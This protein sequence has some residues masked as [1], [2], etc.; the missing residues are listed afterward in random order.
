MPNST[1]I[2]IYVDYFFGDSVLVIVS[3]LVNAS[4]IF[5]LY[6]KV[7]K[8]QEKGVLYRNTSS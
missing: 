4:F 2:D 6:K 8:E 5:L 1:A 3:I 7:F